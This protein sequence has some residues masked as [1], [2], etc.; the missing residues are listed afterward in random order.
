MNDILA[1]VAFHSKSR[2]VRLDSYK[3]SAV[4]IISASVAIGI[5]TTISNAPLVDVC[6]W[7]DI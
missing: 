4:Q 6:A 7:W 2:S 5:S 1:V 3:H